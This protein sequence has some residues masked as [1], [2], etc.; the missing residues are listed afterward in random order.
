MEYGKSGPDWTMAAVRPA[1]KCE[2]IERAGRRLLTIEEAKNELSLSEK[3]VRQ[4]I[5]TRQLT[6]LLICG[7]ER[8]D[9]WD[10]DDLIN[11]YR[12]TAMRR[13]VT[14]SE[15]EDLRKSINEPT[16]RSPVDGE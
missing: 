10:V 5:A 6:L 11:S 7:N 1:V 9:S 2:S 4:L 3:E 15:G 12:Q 8:I 16:P 13:A 14:V